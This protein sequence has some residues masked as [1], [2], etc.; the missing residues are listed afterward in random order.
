LLVTPSGITAAIYEGKDVTR[1]EFLMRVARSFSLAIMQREDDP[2]APVRRVKAD[3]KYQDEA[4][5]KAQAVL[6]EVG[7]LSVAEAGERAKAEYY[8]AAKARQ[9][10]R[11]E[12][13][14]LRGRY[15][16]MI[17]EVEAWEPDPL[18][19]YIKDGALK[20]LRKSLD[21]DCGKPGEEVRYWPVPQWLD[22]AEWIV[23]KT[24][25]ARKDIDYQRE[26]IAK[27]KAVAAER[28]QHI[29]AFLRSLDLDQPTGGECYGGVGQQTI[30]ALIRRQTWRHV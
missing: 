8:D 20:Q 26:Q 6:A 15:E 28:N 25:K 16:A 21:F 14:A 30:S 11:A 10:R 22:G 19:L 3:T 29:D 13:L 7:G 12:V 23:Q 18:V 1:D 24:E 27:R 4:I 9:E 5:E 17:R 2:D